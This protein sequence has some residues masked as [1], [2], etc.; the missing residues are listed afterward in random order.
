MKDLSHLEQWCMHYESDKEAVILELDV[1]ESKVNTLSQQTLSEL[2]Q[3]LDAV[4]SMPKVKRLLIASKKKKGFIAGADINDFQVID[5]R[6]AIRGYLRFGQAV[7]TKLEH[8][9][10]TT[11]A[12]IHGHCFGGGMELALACD[13]RIVSDSES[14]KMGLPE[15]KL[16]IFPGWGG[17]VRLASLLDCAQALSLILR[18]SSLSSKQAC[19]LG[20]AT[21][22]AP[23]HLLKQAGLSLDVSKRQRGN[24]TLLGYCCFSKG[25]RRLIR[26]LTIKTLVK[27][28]VVFDHYPALLAYI[29]HWTRFGA[30]KRGFAGEVEGVSRLLA[31]P[32]TQSL[33]RLFFLKKQLKRLHSISRPIQ[34]IHVIGAGVMGCEIAAVAAYS[35]LS[36]S[37]HDSNIATLEKAY[38][39]IASLWPKKGSYQLSNQLILDS[40]GQC[41]RGADLVIEA[42]PE[43]LSIKQEV[44]NRAAKEAPKHALI[45]T[46]TSSIPLEN[47]VS[48]VNDPTRFLGIHFFN[49]VH[50]MPLV[51]VV[52]HSQLGDEAVAAS[53]CFVLSL[54]K[55]PVRVRSTPGFLVN[56]ILIP[57]LLEAMRMIDEGYH[58]LEI[59]HAMCYFGMP[60]GPLRLCDEIGLDVC[61]AVAETFRSFLCVKIPQCLQTLVH[62]KKLGKKSGQ[63]FYHYPYREKT[64]NECLSGQQEA[65]MAR[66]EISLVNVAAECLDEKIV[67]SSDH[68]DAAM[69]FG[70]GF[71]PFLGGPLYSAKHKGLDYYRCLVNTAQLAGGNTVISDALRRFL[72]NR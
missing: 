12:L 42:V 19:R 58:A 49:P 35:G 3:L 22:T 4:A 65:I 70:T 21:L 52:S 64:F 24:K 7:F 27:K 34:K 43:V 23:T 61:L 53:E 15:L 1:P 29:N 47:L 18:S 6:E 30:S 44:L 56:R 38:H 5:D 2:D 51:E 13:Y 16:G 9:P 8:L 67:E 55:L 37:L 60:M 69:V 33:V 11:I 66:L 25:M 59:D 17:T 62:E 41:I 10:I 39:H 71:A 57:Y 72:E 14:T 31:K 46:N 36:V 28:G 26:F 68:L 40:H 45:A 32:Q 50:K 54:N 48:V 63:G 20:L